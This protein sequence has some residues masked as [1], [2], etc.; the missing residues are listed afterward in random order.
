MSEVIMCVGVCLKTFKAEISLILVEWL[1]KILCMNL[2]S[3]VPSF[4]FALEC[5]L[6]II[7]LRVPSLYYE[8][9]KLMTPNSM[10]Y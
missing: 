3:D 8:M 2:L 5:A 4:E 9:T 1:A 10:H 7:H 6:D